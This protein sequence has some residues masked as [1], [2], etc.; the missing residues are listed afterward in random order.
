MKKVILSVLVVCILNLSGYS[1]NIS[2]YKV[3]DSTNWNISADNFNKNQLSKPG[4]IYS[5][6]IIVLIDDKIY[7]ITSKEFSSLKKENIKESKFIKSTDKNSP[8]QGV[9][10]IKTNIASSDTTEQPAYDTTSIQIGIRSINSFYFCSKLYKIPADCPFGDRSHCCTFESNISKTIP[11]YTAKST[12][13]NGMLNCYGNSSLY[14]NYFE[15]LSNAKFNFDNTLKQL[16]EQTKEF[17]QEPIKL[18]VCGQEVV[19]Y[20][21]ICTLYGGMPREEITFCGTVNGQSLTGSLWSVKS[22]KSSTDLSAFLQQ[23][24]KF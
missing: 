17:K 4:P 11:A 21:V 19:A 1:Q 22:L 2:S 20:R 12:I 8:V 24:F 3:T 5:Q 7:S 10:I 6:E 23:I 16:K 18:Y 15:S 14:W 13:Q 9:I